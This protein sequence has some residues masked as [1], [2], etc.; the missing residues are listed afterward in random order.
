MRFGKH[1]TLMATAAGYSLGLISLTFMPRGQMI[2]VGIFMFLMGFLATSF[3]LLDRAMVADVGDAVRLQYGQ[4]RVGLLYSM[5]TMTQKVAGAL[6]IT[7]S[8]TVLG[9]IGY[10]AK[11]GVVNTPAAIHGLELVYLIGPVVFVML[12]GACYIGYKLNDRRHAEI[13]AALDE[14]DGV[15]VEAPVI[16]GVTGSQAEPGRFAA[17]E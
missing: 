1:R 2:P 12:G 16:D 9:A 11:D 8:F 4:N 17:A 7:L 5:I 6:S 10:Q 14:R 3:A 13:R 15:G